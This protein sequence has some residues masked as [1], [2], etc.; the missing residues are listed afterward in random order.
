MYFTRKQVLPA[1][2]ED[3]TKEGAWPTPPVDPETGAP[4]DYRV[5]TEKRYE[6]CATFSR[7]AEGDPPTWTTDQFWA[8]TAGRQ[9]FGVDVKEPK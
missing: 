1:S 3:I 2:L 8:H 9:C 6:L 5:I 4:Y 7:A